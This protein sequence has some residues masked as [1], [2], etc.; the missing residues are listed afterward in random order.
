MEASVTRAEKINA[1]FSQW[2][3]GKVSVLIN[4]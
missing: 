4:K 3:I 1:L 2:L